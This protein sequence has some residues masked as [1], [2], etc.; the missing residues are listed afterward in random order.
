M[1]VHV[2]YVVAQAT[3]RTVPF[4]I[5]NTSEDEVEIVSGRRIAEFSVLSE[6]PICNNSST[7]NTNPDPFCCS[8]VDTSNLLDEI[9][10]AIDPSL[11]QED[12]AKLRKVLLQYSDVFENTLGQTSVLSHTI[13]TGDS[14]PIKQ[15]PRCLPYAHREEVNKQVKDMLAQGVIK[16]SSS[17]WLSPVVVVRKKVG[18]FRLC[19]DYRKLNSITHCEAHPIPRMVDILDSLNGAKMF[20]TLDLRS[21]YWQVLMD[22]KDKPKTALATRAGQFQFTRMPFGFNS[23]PSTFQRMIEIVSSGLNLITCNCY[24]DDVIIHSKD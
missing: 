13:D 3:S 4:R 24:L 19:I 6:S 18:T 16:P 20:T 22:P 15:R 21:G 17:P 7:A 10:A 11:N 14:P 9:E 8:S 23:A 1:G 5:A 2:A 12:K